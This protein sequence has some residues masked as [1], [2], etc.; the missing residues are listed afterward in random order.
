M[1]LIQIQQSVYKNI[2]LGNLK[3]WWKVRFECRLNEKHGEK[4]QHR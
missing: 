4:A 2:N 3:S 1:G